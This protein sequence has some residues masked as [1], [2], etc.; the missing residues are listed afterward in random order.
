VIRPTLVHQKAIIAIGL[1][2]ENSL[3]RTLRYRPT[4]KLNITDLLKQFL[5]VAVYLA[6]KWCIW[7]TV[8]SRVIFVCL[9]MF[10]YN[11]KTIVL[12][13]VPVRYEARNN[14]A[15]E[16]ACHVNRWYK[17]VQKTPTTHQV[18]LH[19]IHEYSLFKAIQIILYCILHSCS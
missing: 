15:E 11:K 18:E 6:H 19:N 1:S 3:L 13:Y 16:H 4:L 12:D 2:R 14:W 5:E 8:Y 9:M 17:L 10:L 7:I